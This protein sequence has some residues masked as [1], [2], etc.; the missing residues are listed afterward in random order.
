MKVSS[1]VLV[2]VAVLVVVVDAGKRRNAGRCRP[3]DDRAHVADAVIHLEEARAALWEAESIII[4]AG[5]SF[6]AD[7]LDIPVPSDRTAPHARPDHPIRHPNFTA[8]FAGFERAFAYNM[9]LHLDQV[10]RASPCTADACD[11]IMFEV[12]S[13]MRC[14]DPSRFYGDYQA[15][16]LPNLYARRDAGH[17]SLSARSFWNDTRVPVDHLAAAAT[18]V[19]HQATSTKNMLRHMRIDR[20]L[21]HGLYLRA[22]NLSLASAEPTAPVPA[23]AQNADVVVG[24]LLASTYRMMLLV[25]QLE[26][27]DD[28]Y[29]CAFDQLTS[30]R[31]HIKQCRYLASLESLL[32]AE[33]E[34]CPR[35]GQPVAA[36]PR[37]RRSKKKRSKHDAKPNLL[38]TSGHTSPANLTM[39]EERAMEPAV[40]EEVAGN[41]SDVPDQ[42]NRPMAMVDD[43]TSEPD[44]SD[45]THDDDLDAAT[46]D[47]EEHS[48]V[49]DAK[50]EENGRSSETSSS[51]EDG[52]DPSIRHQL[53]LL[54]ETLTDSDESA[55][56][57]VSMD[58][59]VS[60]D[61]LSMGDQGPPDPDMVHIVLGIE[62]LLEPV[63][64]PTG[65]D[66]LRRD[67]SQFLDWVRDA[68][69]MHDGIRDLVRRQVDRVIRAKFPGAAVVPTLSPVDDLYQQAPFTNVDLTIRNVD[70][71]GDSVRCLKDVRATL[72]QMPVV[73]SSVSLVLAPAPRL[74]FKLRD[75]PVT[76]SLSWNVLLP[77]RF[78]AEAVTKY[79]TIEPV[80][81]FAWYFL[82]RRGLHEASQGGVGWQLLVVMV[83]SHVQV[84]ADDC[85]PESQG[86]CLRSFFTYYGTRFDYNRDCISVAGNGRLF[87]RPDRGATPPDE[88]RLC[89]ESPHDPNVDLG[90]H[91]SR[92]GAVVDAFKTASGLLTDYVPGQLLSKDMFGC[93][94]V[95]HVVCP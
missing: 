56:D 82:L 43:A 22:L 79:P 33:P 12:T 26:H 68:R 8:A 84:N 60:N 27:M 92:I 37:R 13:L 32:A 24:R 6:G 94:D 44:V 17:V 83:V 30:A 90:R 28:L 18:M 29:K 85:Q 88:F 52:T 95:A 14:E 64:H 70:L 45:S 49:D 78:A 7:L 93:D 87:P 66:H 20:E 42:P 1:S 39:N 16:V 53:P 81:L 77:N 89:A 2:A 51:A 34:P 15:R 76:V 40:H 41:Q 71:P 25:K 48:I 4:S 9:M 86:R 36:K 69:V 57:D 72:S 54:T 65:D 63:D 62:K 80:L 38:K 91:A 59:C 10:S 35:P 3:V 50:D 19:M 58:V 67:L 55:V 75:F 73:S 31:A 23:S 21:L 5:R 74:V 11:K 47:H 46:C 61:D